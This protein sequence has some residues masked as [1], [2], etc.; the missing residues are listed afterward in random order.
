[1]MLMLPDRGGN[2]VV[3]GLA[4][5]GLAGQKPQPGHDPLSLTGRV[6]QPEPVKVVSRVGG[7]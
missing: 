5:H 3:F 7:S 6:R 4:G 1:M 2:R